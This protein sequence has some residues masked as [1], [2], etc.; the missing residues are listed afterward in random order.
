[1]HALLMKYSRYDCNIIL[2]IQDF[3]LSLYADQQQIRRQQPRSQR[4]AK[5]SHA[6]P[7]DRDPSMSG[8]TEA[9]AIKPAGTASFTFGNIQTPLSSQVSRLT[10]TTID[11]SLS[12]AATP[13]FGTGFVSASNLQQSAG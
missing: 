2:C 13:V 9:K 8:D 3:C 5:R 11:T 6:S 4:P 12:F 10:H 7:L 1:M